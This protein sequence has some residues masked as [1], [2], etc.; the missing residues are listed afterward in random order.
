[1]KRDP[2][3]L[4]VLRHEIRIYEKGVKLFERQLAE[5]GIVRNGSRII[6]LKDNGIG[7]G[8][9]TG[10]NFPFSNAAE[11]HPDMREAALR[12]ARQRVASSADQAIHEL[13]QRHHAKN[14][15]QSRS[16][17]GGGGGGGSGDSEADDTR[18]VATAN[19]GIAIIDNRKRRGGLSRIHQE[20][21]GSRGGLFGSSIGHIIGP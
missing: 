8:A 19:G 7:G 3:V 20:K 6:V 18:E 15:E 21:Y 1:M 4:E 16:G 17:G 2:E 13:I 14:H 10:A 11:V 12:D 5:C 9:G